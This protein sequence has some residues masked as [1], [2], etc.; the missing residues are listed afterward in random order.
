MF[1]VTK[2]DTRRSGERKRA[3]AQG[4]AFYLG[5]PCKHGHPAALRPT[6]SGKCL[7]CAKGIITSKIASDN[8]AEAKEH[9]NLTYKGKECKY[10]HDGQRY[11]KDG[12]CVKCKTTQ[13]EQ[14]SEWRSKMRKEG[15]L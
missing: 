11:A 9:S 13:N 2:G 15:V 1:P 6:G 10:Q 8:R 12:S 5:S 4:H 3:L 7:A 14:F